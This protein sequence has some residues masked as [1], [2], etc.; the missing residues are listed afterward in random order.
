LPLGKD[1]WNHSNK[2]RML[3]CG[4]VMRA[5]PFHKYQSRHKACQKCASTT[6]QAHSGQADVTRIALNKIEGNALT[7]NRFLTFSSEAPTYL[8][9]ISGPF[10]TLGSFP[11]SILPICRAISVF[12]A[13]WS[14]QT[15]TSHEQMNAVT[16]MM[17][18]ADHSNKH[19]HQCRNGKQRHPW[20]CK[21]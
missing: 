21:D 18:L 13:H 14:S 12:P 2:L 4:H 7:L 5:V 1:A 20:T 19:K 11:F 9:R 6:Y 17:S 8:L 10:T 15:H 16:G 3:A